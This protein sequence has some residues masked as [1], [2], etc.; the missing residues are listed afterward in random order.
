MISRLKALISLNPM[1]LSLNGQQ[2][3]KLKSKQED[4]PA[5]LL[6]ANLEEGKGEGKLKKTLYG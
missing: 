2:L 1:L 4:I 6:H 3:L 5:A